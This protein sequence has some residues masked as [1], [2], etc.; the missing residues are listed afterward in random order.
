MKGK[1]E[2]SFLYKEFWL[3]KTPEYF[4]VKFQLLT[5]AIDIMFAFYSIMSIPLY[6]FYHLFGD[7]GLFSNKEQ[8][9]SNPALK[10]ELLSYYKLND[11]CLFWNIFNIFIPIGLI[12]LSL[13]TIRVQ[14]YAYFSVYLGIQ[15]LFIFAYFANSNLTLIPDKSSFI[16]KIFHLMLFFSY[17]LYFIYSISYYFKSKKPIEININTDKDT[18][19]NKYKINISQQPASLDTLVHEVQLRMDMAK[20][21]FNSIMIKLKLHKI[22]RRFMYQKKDFYFMNREQEREREN[23]NI[24]RNI[25]GLKNLNNIKCCDNKSVLSDN[26]STTFASS[27]DNNYSKLD[28]DDES[29]PL[30]I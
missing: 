12:I 16:Y 8:L 6:I 27:V 3:K 22:F 25:K 5:Y 17:S 24:I 10:A 23:N 4:N 20:M 1:N 30:K 15:K 9:E 29:E 18:S 13:S 21:K 14:T 2:N 28:D 7:L 19:Y 26:S 11:I